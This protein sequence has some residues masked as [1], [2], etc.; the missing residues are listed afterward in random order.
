MPDSLGTLTL[1]EVFGSFQRDL[2]AP[3]NWALL[4]ATQSAG[5]KHHDDKRPAGLEPLQL[6]VLRWF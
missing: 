4:S 5:H 6:P 1:S 3:F 2:I